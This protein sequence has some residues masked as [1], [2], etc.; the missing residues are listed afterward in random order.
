MRGRPVPS[1]RNNWKS[2]NRSVFDEVPS[3]GNVVTAP[4]ADAGAAVVCEGVEPDL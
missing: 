4:A 3:S 1:V 2:D